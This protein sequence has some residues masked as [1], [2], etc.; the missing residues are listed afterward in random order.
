MSAKHQASV[1][2]LP[3]DFLLHQSIIGKKV[4]GAFVFLFYICFPSKIKA[5]ILQ[6]KL[7]SFLS[8]KTIFM[9]RE[10]KT[11]SYKTKITF[12]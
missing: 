9:D 6:S 12:A 4:N 7:L 11:T 1:T 8:P 10:S 3:E 5:C 2:G